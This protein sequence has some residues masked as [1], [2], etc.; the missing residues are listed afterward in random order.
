MHEGEDVTLL[1]S[2][3]LPSSGGDLLDH[4]LAGEAARKAVGEKDGR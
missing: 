1:L 4:V 2:V 3:A